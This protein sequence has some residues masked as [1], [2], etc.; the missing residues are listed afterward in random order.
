[1]L[2]L[3]LGLAFRLTVDFSSLWSPANEAPSD[4]QP[5]GRVTVQAPG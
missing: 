1:M 3:P 5:K 4:L 2:S